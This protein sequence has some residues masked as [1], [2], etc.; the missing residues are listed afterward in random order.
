M[1]EKCLNENRQ[2]V[3]GNDDSDVRSQCSVRGSG[4]ISMHEN[5]N[6]APIACVTQD[7]SML[8]SEAAEFM[9]NGG[10]TSAKGSRV[11]PV[12]L[13]TGKPPGGGLSTDVPGF[14][15]ELEE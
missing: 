9:C 11:V 12:L 7:E 5:D 2:P 1:L 6:E 14:A 4:E 8:H 13:L 15:R 10:G 3:I